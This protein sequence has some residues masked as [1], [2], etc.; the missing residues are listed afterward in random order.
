VGRFGGLVVGAALTPAIQCGWEAE[1]A[2]TISAVTSRRLGGE[3]VRL[4]AIDKRPSVGY[5]DYSVPYKC[6]STTV[7]I[8]GL[9]A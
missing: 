4:H 2:T 5:Y 8:P 6:G 3:A 9:I 1:D 7:V